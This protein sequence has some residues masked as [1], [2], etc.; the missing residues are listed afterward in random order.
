M[1]MVDRSSLGVVQHNIIPYVRLFLITSLVSCLSKGTHPARFF[2]K[3]GCHF[4]SGS[5]IKSDFYR[6]LKPKSSKD[7]Y[8]YIPQVQTKSLCKIS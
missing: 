5:V 7:M 2:K 4:S 6:E 3:I 1:F 8:R